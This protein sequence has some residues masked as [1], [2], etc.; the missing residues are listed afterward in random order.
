MNFWASMIAFAAASVLVYVALAIN[1]KTAQADGHDHHGHDD[2][3]HGKG[4]H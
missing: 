4:H 2:H 3:G 1:G